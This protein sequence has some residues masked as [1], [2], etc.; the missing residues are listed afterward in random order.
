VVALDPDALRGGH[1]LYEDDLLLPHDRIS[2]H[3]RR[4]VSLS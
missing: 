4:L 3:G 1:A 2:R